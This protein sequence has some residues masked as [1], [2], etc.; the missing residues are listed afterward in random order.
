MGRPRVRSS[1]V[2][3]K[4]ESRLIDPLNI[5]TSV[6]TLEFNVAH[7]SHRFYAKV[8][9]L[10]SAVYN[11]LTGA[12]AANPLVAFTLIKRL[13]SEWPNVVYSEEAQENTQGDLA[14]NTLV[15]KHTADSKSGAHPPFQNTPTP[16]PQLKP[17][18][19]CY[20]T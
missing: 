9:Q 16:S 11:R 15:S 2:R 1:S 6:V 20:M 7:C 19:F 5:R 4:A 10:H 18:A 13:H 17:K 12:A 8:S 3:Q 14:L